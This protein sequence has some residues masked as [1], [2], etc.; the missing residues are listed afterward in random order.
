MKFHIILLLIALFIGVAG[1]QPYNDTTLNQR[2]AELK[3]EI[4]KSKVVAP[5][6]NS[7]DNTDMEALIS[8]M[9]KSFKDSLEAIVSKIQTE[10]PLTDSKITELNK[11]VVKLSVI[12]SKLEI[13]KDKRVELEDE[14][15]KFRDR[16]NR[17]ENAQVKVETETLKKHFETQNEILKKLS[18]MV[19]NVSN[20]APAEVTK[21]LQAQY[22]EM[23]K[24]LEEMEASKTKLEEDLKAANE[25]LVKKDKRIDAMKENISALEKAIENGNK[26]DNST[27]TDEN[28][29]DETEIPDAAVKT[30]TIVEVVLGADKESYVAIVAF[31][32]GTKVIKGFLFSVFNDKGEKIG[33]FKVSAENLPGDGSNDVWIGGSITPSKGVLEIKK[34]FR[35]S[36]LLTM[37]DLTKSEK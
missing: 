21:Q 37:P 26:G 14:I 3:D 8:S 9:N 19:E 16:L 32:A 18:Q 31:P 12:V 15:I 2:I 20:T 30:G 33:R 25:E 23:S 6:V 27:A 34:G 1:C 7:A 28:K 13:E 5:V 22:D 17:I 35:V 10:S 36:T 29:T 11:E 24:K 4:E